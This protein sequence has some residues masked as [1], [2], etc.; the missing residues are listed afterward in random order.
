[1][2]K[3]SVVFKRSAYKDLRP[4][5]QTDLKPILAGL[6]ALAG[7]PRGPGCEKLSGRERYRAQQGVYRI[8]Y[9]IKDIQLLVIIVRIGHRGHV[10]ER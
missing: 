10:Y 5:S 3:Y 7:D 2:A 4:I 8:I 9:E 1:M 6:N